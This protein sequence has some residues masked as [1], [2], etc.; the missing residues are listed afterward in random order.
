MKI[1]MKT[2]LCFVIA[3]LFVIPLTAQNSQV[4]A[5][6]YSTMER[7]DIPVE[8]T[9]RI[10]DIYPT[11]EN[12]QKDKEQFI[13]MLG[14]IDKMAENWTSSPQKMLAMLEFRDEIQKKDSR[15]FAYASH[16]NNTDLGNST[17]RAMKGDLQAILVKS[18]TKIAFMDADILKLGKET[19]DNY[20]KAEP[21]LTPY[22][23]GCDNVFRKAAHILPSDQGQIVSMTGTF[24]GIPGT[25]AGILN[26]V[27]LPTPEVTFSG[28]N[29]VILNFANFAKYRESKIRSDRELAAKTYWEN[30]KKFANTFAVLLDGEM[31]RHLFNARVHKYQDCL[32]AAL[33]NINIDPVVYHNLIKYVRENLDPF[34]RYWAVKK[35]L[36]GLDKFKYADVYASAVEKVDKTY[37]YDE[38]KT[39]ILS[40][41]KPLGSEYTDMVRQALDNRWIDVYPNKGKQVGAYSGG[42][43]GVHPF[44]KMNYDGSYSSVSTLAHELGHAMHT[45]F[46]NKTQPFARAGYSIFLAEVASTFNEN[47]LMQYL[48]KYEKDDLFKLFILDN[49]IQQ[50][51]GA[52]YRQAQF[53]EFELAM[54]REV[55][56]DRTL[57]PQWLNQK[58]LELTR[59]YYGHDKGVVDVDDYIQDEWASI[60]H[61]YRNYYVYTYSTGMIASMAL[62][63]MVLNGKLPER[64]KFLAFLKAGGN[65]YP[66]DILKL[67]GVDM[68]TPVPYQAAFKRIGELVSEME[69]ITAR[70]K[71]RK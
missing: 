45:Y 22:V 17:F 69:K 15:L 21:K 47:L 61:F 62:S 20:V 13:Q 28:G 14:Q 23:F 16:Q 43:Y 54:H 29:K 4:N 32:E 44:I 30:H 24:A 63:D 58:Y 9:W 36:L 2:L 19:F 39:I 8:Y 60:P 50:I 51:K 10:E 71:K 64:E 12:W 25:A 1:K 31:K 66:L 38:A 40:A 35:E 46:S 5:P 41:L 52:L 34:F 3:V 11:V 7:K 26:N 6:D 56:A 49:F 18:H 57:T 48:L 70:L 67:A 27:E 53:A 55:E 59:F 42:V 37:T 33:Y 65:G 68:T